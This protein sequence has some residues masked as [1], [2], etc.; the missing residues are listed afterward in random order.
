VKVRAEDG[1]GKVTCT[2]TVT[3]KAGGNDS[4]PCTTF[5]L[6]HIPAGQQYTVQV[7]AA[8][9][10]GTSKPD[11]AKVTTDKLSGTVR[12]VGPA[13]DDYCNG[14]PPRKPGIG[15]YSTTSQDPGAW[16]YQ[17]MNGFRTVGVCKRPGDSINSKFYNGNKVSS[18]WVRFEDGK[19][20]PFAW[21]NLDGADK[22]W[23]LAEC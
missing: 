2:M 5:S 21:F 19:Y 16:A 3:G 22:D 15:V 14:I 10:A 4:G 1:G 13:G 9:A 7:K 23:Q 8:N 18:W 11:T 12:C 17:R 20:I 6:G